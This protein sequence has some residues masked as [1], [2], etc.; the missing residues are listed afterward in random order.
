MPPLTVLS[1][2][3]LGSGQL[4]WSCLSVVSGWLLSAV[5]LTAPSVPPPQVTLLIG[6]CDEL[7]TED[8]CTV[9]FDE[10][11]FTALAKESVV[12]QLGKLLWHTHAKT[13]G[14]QTRDADAGAPPP[15]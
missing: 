4:V 8:F 10:F 11:F 5:M 9:I 1:E 15:A 13:A 6:M 3:C 12:Q 7:A 2:P 14:G